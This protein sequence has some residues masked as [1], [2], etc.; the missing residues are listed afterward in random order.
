MTFNICK[1]CSGRCCQ[2]FSLTRIGE[3][4]NG[5]EEREEL[6]K[7]HESYVQERYGDFIIHNP[8]SEQKDDPNTDNWWKC[9]KYDDETKLCTIYDERPDFCR[10]Y[11]CEEH[12]DV[13]YLITT[14]LREV[15]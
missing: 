7:E 10:K 12:N 3:D 9:L 2:G 14:D 15:I 1:K 13:M 11:F 6:V 4:E 8:Y 5:E